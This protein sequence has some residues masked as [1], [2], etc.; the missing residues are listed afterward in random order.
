MNLLIRLG[1]YLA[2]LGGFTEQKSIAIS[3]VKPSITSK[4]SIHDRI[5]RLYIEHAF[6][7]DPQ[8][9]I[10]F[11]DEII[12]KEFDYPK[13]ELIEIYNQVIEE[14]T[15]YARATIRTS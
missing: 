10:L 7:P 12:S 9:R 8:D 6:I 11:I 15:D 3:I 2:R 14:N 5:R 1:L 4:K 13:V